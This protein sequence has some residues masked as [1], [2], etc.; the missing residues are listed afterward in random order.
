MGDTTT[1]ANPTADLAGSQTGTESALSNWVGP[2]VTSML[3]QGAALAATPYQ[4]YSGPLTAGQS[5]LQNQAFQGLSSLAMPTSTMGAY[6]PSSFTDQGMAQ[7]YMNPYLQASLAPQIA[8]AQRQAEIQR[9]QNAGRMT[10]AGAYGGDRQAILEAEGNRNLATGLA[11]IVGTGYNQAYNQAQSQY[12]T[13]EQRRQAAQD[14]TNQYGFNLANAQQTAGATQR[15]IEGEG[16]AAD[17]SQ[18]QQER[19]YPYKQVQYMQSLLQGLPVATQNYS[20]QQPSGLSSLMGTSGGIL[21]FLNS[22]FGVSG[23][24]VWSWL[25]SGNSSANTTTPPTG[26]IN[27][28][29]VT[30]SNNIGNNYGG[31]ALKPINV[32]SQPGNI[33]NNYKP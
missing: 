33:G 3:G 25:T 30:N 18:F 15:G 13:E 27:L 22:N 16:I 24:D 9:V 23:S 31:S 4:A 19:D 14:Q 32:F 7:Q 28:A 6:T 29:G 17:M 1:A 21:D 10:K 2:Y 26:N 8:E 5:G 11:G 12:N 20:Y